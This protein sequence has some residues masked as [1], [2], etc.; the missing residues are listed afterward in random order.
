MRDKLKLLLEKRGGRVLLLGVVAALALILRLYF[1]IG[2]TYSMEQDEGIYLTTVHR[3][4]TGDFSVHFADKPADY[5][6][7]PAECFQFR[8]A[9]LYIPF[10]FYKILGVSD[11]STVFFSLLCSIATVVLAFHTGRLLLG[12]SAGLAA[13]LLCAIYPLDVLYSTRL[14]PDGPMAF[15]FWLSLYL[16]LRADRCGNATHR[17]MNYKSLLYLAAGLS[18]GVCYTIRLTMVF[19]AVLIAMQMLYERR[20]DRRQF[21]VLAGFCLIL[22]AEGSYFMWHGDDFFLNFKINSRMYEGKFLTERPDALA[23]IPGFLNCWFVEAIP[24]YYAQ[25]ILHSL[26]SLKENPFGFFWAATIA[27]VLIVLIRREKRLYLMAA[28]LVALYLL[29][30]F[31]PVRLTFNTDGA[32]INY[33]LLVQRVRYLTVMVLPSAVLTAYLLMQLQKIRLAGALYIALAVTSVIAIHHYYEYLRAG[34]AAINQA[35]DY[36]HQLPPKTIYTDFMAQHHIQYRFGFTRDGEIKNFGDMN[37]PLSDAYVVLGGSRGMD[38]SPATMTDLTE[39]GMRK[40]DASWRLLQK[41]ANPANNFEPYPDLFIY[42]IPKRP[43]TES[44]R[45]APA[46]G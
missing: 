6:P 14:M 42:L 27:A 36:L 22:I 15:F 28:W 24:F 32:L 29:H 41:I 1:F 20:V 25:E 39:K 17:L 37:G 12:P 40:K 16:F 33:Y 35:C 11:F 8:Y 4:C 3:V 18:I 46:D 30:E 45:E 7:N 19:I 31:F 44:L 43:P 23:L 38:V 9:L 26:R 13:A 2:I 10:F 5:I 21:M 34:V